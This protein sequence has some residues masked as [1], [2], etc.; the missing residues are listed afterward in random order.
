MEDIERTDDNDRWIKIGRTA[1]YKH[2]ITPP[3]LTTTKNSF[4]ILSVSN[5]LTS[6]LAAPALTPSPI[7]KKQTTE[8]SCSTQKN[9]ANNAK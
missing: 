3:V 2:K 5:A 6:T 9:T 8:P 4:A 7:H 1:S